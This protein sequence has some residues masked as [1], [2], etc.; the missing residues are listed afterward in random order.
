MS[1]NLKCPCCGAAIIKHNELLIKEPM[2]FLRPVL[3]PVQPRGPAPHHCRN[4]ICEGD[5]WMVR[6]AVQQREDGR[7]RDCGAS[8]VRSR[9]QCFGGV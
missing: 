8:N 5:I 6:A 2:F 7:G 9:G 1:E 3:L 4:G